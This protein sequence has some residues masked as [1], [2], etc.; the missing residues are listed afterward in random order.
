[1][2]TFVNFYFLWALIILPQTLQA[3]LFSVSGY[4]IDKLSEQA[5][6]NAN[7]YESHSGIGTITN[8]EGYFRLLLNRGPQNLKISNGGFE[9]FFS[10]FNL[11]ADTIITVALVP[12]NVPL[13]KMVADVNP[14]KG[15]SSVHEKQEPARKRK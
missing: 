9:H 11:K 6:E 2:K 13:Y 14:Q 1:M 12:Q 8:S 4:V 7:V 5:V 10:T 15:D 3:Q